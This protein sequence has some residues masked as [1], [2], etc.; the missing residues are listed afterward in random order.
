MNKIEQ[1]KE[2]NQLKTDGVVSQEEF[3]SLKDE[4]MSSGGISNNDEVD[5]MLSYLEGNNP[6]YGNQLTEGVEFDDSHLKSSNEDS[7]GKKLYDLSIDP[8]AKEAIKNLIK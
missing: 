1:L 7:S 3:D 5:E 6:E 4:I 8:W 2:L